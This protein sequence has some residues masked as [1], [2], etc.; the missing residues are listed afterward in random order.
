MNNSPNQLLNRT[1]GG[2][3]APRGLL[4]DGAGFFSRWAPCTGRQEYNVPHV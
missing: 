3:V 4:L 2:I 1:P